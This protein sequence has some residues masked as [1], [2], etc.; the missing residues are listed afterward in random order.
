LLA[1][2]VLIRRGAPLLSDRIDPLDPYRH[3]AM[4]VSSLEGAHALDELPPGHVS[5]TALFNERSM[6][7]VNVQET[8]MNVAPA[9]SYRWTDRRASTAPDTLRGRRAP[10]PHGCT[11]RS[12]TGAARLDIPLGSSGAQVEISFVPRS[13]ADL[14]LRTRILKA[15]H[16]SIQSTWILD[17]RW[18]LTGQRFFVASTMHH[19]LLQVTFPAGRVEVCP[20]G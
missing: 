18:D 8:R 13:R 14:A 20:A 19:A 10:V 3:P 16:A 7:Q 9:T 12:T 17:S 1:T 15:S 2:A 11:A 6:L 5:S 4:S